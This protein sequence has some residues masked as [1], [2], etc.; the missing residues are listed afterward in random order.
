MHYVAEP[1]SWRIVL[2]I[3]VNTIATLP[4]ACLV[5]PSNLSAACQSLSNSHSNRDKAETKSQSAADL[6]V[7]GSM[8][9]MRHEVKSA[10]PAMSAGVMLQGT[11]GRQAYTWGH[12]GGR[13]GGRD[14]GGR[15]GAGEDK[16]GS[17]QWS[18]KGEPP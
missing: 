4:S 16:C 9:K 3:G 7:M 10:R 1:S 17:K 13:E 12:Q 11:L 8:L 14:G 2:Q 6:A 5:G 18:E 15:E